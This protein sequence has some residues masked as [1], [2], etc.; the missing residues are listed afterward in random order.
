[1]ADPRGRPFGHEGVMFAS[2]HVINSRRRPQRNPF[3]RFYLTAK[4][5]CQNVGIL[6]DN[7]QG[8][9]TLVES[10]AAILEK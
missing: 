4:F 9:K 5:H 8:G 6:G 3:W 10:V 2:S 1:M 7:R